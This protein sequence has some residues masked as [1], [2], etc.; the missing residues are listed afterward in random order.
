MSEL[1]NHEVFDSIDH[2]KLY[3]EKQEENR[4]KAKEKL[5]KVSYGELLDNE[6]KRAEFQALSSVSIG[7]MGLVVTK[8]NAQ[9]LPIQVSDDKKLT[10]GIYGEKKEYAIFHEP[11]TCFM[12]MRN[13]WIIGGFVQKIKF[14][15]AMIWLK[16]LGMSQYG[17]LKFNLY[18][19]R[20]DGEYTLDPSQDLT[21]LENQRL[22][23]A[24]L[25]IANPE[26]QGKAMANMLEGLGDPEPWWKTAQ[27]LITILLIVAM[28]LFVMNGGF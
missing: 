17:L 11:Q 8:S 14:K 5:K 27:W 28:F 10:C 1:E 7:N 16:I 25:K 26:L 4:E 18:L 3:E 13:Y 9:I 23:E 6:V 12:D 19:F 22:V 15:I 2:Q 21:P 24:F 20:A